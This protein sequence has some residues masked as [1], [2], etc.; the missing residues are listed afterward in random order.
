MSPGELYACPACGRER[1]SP[2]SACDACPYVPEERETAGEVDIDLEDPSAIHAPHG[3]AATWAEFRSSGLLWWTNRALLPFGW[4]IVVHDPGDGHG[5]A[6]VER[7]PST[8]MSLAADIVGR[9]KLLAWTRQ[10][11]PRLVELAASGEIRWSR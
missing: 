10:H 4:M 6:T 7:L 5:A 3:T 9:A 11:A 1:I 8:R 2:S